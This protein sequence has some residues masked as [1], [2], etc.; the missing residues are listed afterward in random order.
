MGCF[1]N[2]SQLLL[3]IVASGVTAVATCAVFEF[4]IRESADGS[5]RTLR[6][7]SFS[8]NDVILIDRAGASFC[9]I[10]ANS[11]IDGNGAIIR[12]EPIIELHDGRN[13]KSRFRVKL[14]KDEGNILFMSSPD[15]K[16]FLTVTSQEDGSAIL[17]SGQDGKKTL[18]GINSLTGELVITSGGKRLLPN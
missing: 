16:S 8:A 9:S 13:N 12:T 14:S 18:V 3:C 11:I 17:Y 4:A 1:V 15:G 7:D 5:F 6:C 10:R 2:R